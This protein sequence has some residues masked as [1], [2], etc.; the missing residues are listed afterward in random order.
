[1]NGNDR[2]Q[3]YLWDPSAPAA[4]DAESL[5]RRLAPLRFDPM[6]QP[7]DMTRL[8]VTVS[9]LAR[10]RRPLVAFAVAASLLFAIG[11]GLWTWRWRWPEGR[12]WTVSAGAV[13]LKLQVGQPMTV[14][15]DEAIGNIA[16]IGTMRLSAGT[17]MELRATGGTRHRLR[18]QGG[19]VH[20]RVWAPPGSLVIETPA[21]EV[22]D[23]GCEFR[24]SVL[25]METRVQVLSGWVQLENGVDEILVPAGASTEMTDRDAPGVP[26]FDDA[27]AEFRADVRAFERAGDR[28]ALARALAVARPRDVY[29][30]LHLTEDHPSE[31]EPMLRRAAELSPPP[32]GITIASIL[33]GNRQ[34]LFTWIGA[35]PLPPPKSS[36]MKNWR[37]ALPFW[38]S[39]R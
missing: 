19:A 8:D 11:A 33:R 4:P 6:A 27:P 2:L 20:V 39:E 23:F 30:L 29:T 10:W 38:L 22:I 32:G 34:N 16:R 31:A 37:D 25:G 24:L 35:Q 18:M 14:P 21:G 12:P 17:S 15:Q 36:W 7:L 5:E 13:D 3:D 28:A 9:P 26:V 1:M